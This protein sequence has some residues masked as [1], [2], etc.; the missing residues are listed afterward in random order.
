MEQEQIK[1][2]CD[3]TDDKPF[4]AFL[5]ELIFVIQKMK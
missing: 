5:R 3:A 4:Q 1:K 2:M